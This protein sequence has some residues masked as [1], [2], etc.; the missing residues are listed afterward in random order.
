MLYLSLLI[1]VSE[2]VRENNQCSYCNVTGICSSTGVSESVLTLFMVMLSWLLQ[3]INE[4]E[5]EIWIM[6]FVTWNAELGG[7]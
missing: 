5:K 3:R 6:K 7:V 4:A 2:L 1:W